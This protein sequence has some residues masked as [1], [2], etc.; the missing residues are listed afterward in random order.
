MGTANPN[1][2]RDLLRARIA[3]QT[4]REVKAEREGK[5][6]SQP[7]TTWNEAANERL[8]AQAHKDGVYLSIT[9][10]RQLWRVK[11]TVPYWATGRSRD[12][13]NRQYDC[14]STRRDDVTYRIDLIARTCTCGGWKVGNCPHIAVALIVEST[15][16]EAMRDS[17]YVT[18]DGDRLRWLTAAEMFQ[19]ANDRVFD[20][21][22][23]IFDIRQQA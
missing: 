12:Y 5:T 20:C 22:A 18:R 6:M 11:H 14:P 3:D 7:L 4:T 13:C 9:S 10:G 16:L 1:P 23:D 8:L 15:H 17:I 21:H 2:K 19:S